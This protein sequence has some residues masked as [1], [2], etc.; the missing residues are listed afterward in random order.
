M[1]APAV[2][3]P[4]KR[5]RPWGAIVH[6]PYTHLTQAHLGTFEPALARLVAVQG[7]SGPV[8]LDLSHTRAIDA[9]GV[10][11][12]WRLHHTLATSG[13]ALVVTEA[14]AAVRGALQLYDGPMVLGTPPPPPLTT[15][16]ALGGACY[17]FAHNCQQA[18]ALVADLAA[19]VP[20]WLMRPKHTR[21]LGG[22]SVERHMVLMGS[23]AASVVALIAFLVGV[24]VALQSAAQLRQFG[25][26]L[27]VADLIGVAVTR[28]LGPLMAAIL[29]AG[30][31]GSAISAEL[32]TMVITE[33]LDAL[34]VMGIHPTGHLV[35][36]RLVALT[37][38]QPLLTMLANAVA[39]LGGLCVA[40]LY[41]DIA[42]S[43][44]VH[45]L[46]EAVSLKDVYTGLFKSVVFAWL[47]VVTGAHCG[48]HTQGGP[49]A[50][51]KSTTKS[52][53]VAIF[54]I[55]VADAAASL[56]F[57]FGAD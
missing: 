44:Y 24:T 9:V 43:A 53:V 49:E 25:A 57:Y 35:L 37:C 47:I 30:R 18:F 6:H 15:L 52:V 8:V 20:G 50:V 27:L 34:R 10:A 33:E 39:I 23:Q 46:E 54:A 31:T 26:G 12:L 19:A 17:D 32:A 21:G 7:G 16:Q 56:L 51:G 48:L 40:V 22:Q 14:S 5:L 3:A 1:G 28:E 38:A 42:P 4:P 41:L 55:I 2:D 36:P 45:R 11:V 29:V 13:R